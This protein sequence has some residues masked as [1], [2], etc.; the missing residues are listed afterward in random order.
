MALSFKHDLEAAE[1][2]FR[3]ALDVIEHRIQI[4]QQEM[5]AAIHLNEEE[6]SKLEAEITELQ[7]LLPEMR[8]KI[9]DCQE[10][11]RTGGPQAAK[12]EAEESEKLEQQIIDQKTRD[13]Q[14]KPVT[15]LT[16]LVK[17][18]RD[19]LDDSI[20][21]KLRSQNKNSHEHDV[22]ANGTSNGHSQNGHSSNG[23]LNGKPAADLDESMAE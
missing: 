13:N 16:H 8:F 9:E 2:S 12:V 20:S 3:K 7:G 15:N 21:K 19:E 10:Q 14:F 18:K 1:Q 6:R 11:K 17:R 22:H 5:T 23:D 4:K